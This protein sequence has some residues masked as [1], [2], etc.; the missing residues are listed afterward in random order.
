[1]LVRIDYGAGWQVQLG[2]LVGEIV[3]EFVTRDARRARG[4]VLDMI[5]HPSPKMLLALI[6]AT[7]VPNIEVTA[8]QCRNIFERF[9]AHG[10]FQVVALA[11][12]ANKPMVEM[13]AAI[14]AAALRELA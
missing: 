3:I 7:G 4:A 5:Y 8:A 14:I 9:C 10:S 11:G 1:M 2:G 12:T 13:D 6:P